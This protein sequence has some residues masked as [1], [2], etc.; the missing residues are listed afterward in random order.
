MV[1]DE[2]IWKELRIEA[3]I[4]EK[5]NVFQVF[6]S[7]AQTITQVFLSGAW[8]WI[9]K[10]KTWAGNSKY[11]NKCMSCQNSTAFHTYFLVLSAETDAAI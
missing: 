2:S 9:V 11:M 8:D 3:L 10:F 4:V 5:F 7:T 1:T 6:A